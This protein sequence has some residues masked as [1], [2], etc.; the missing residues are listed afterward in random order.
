MCFQNRDV[1]RQVC[2][3]IGVLFQEGLGNA[4]SPGVHVNVCAV[5]VRGGDLQVGVCCACLHTSVCGTACV[6]VPVC[7]PRGN[8]AWLTWREWVACGRAERGKAGLHKSPRLL[9]RVRG[10]EAAA[11]RL[12]VK[13]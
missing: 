6:Y 3:E 8:R 2:K 12:G 5:C 7:A 9:C 10:Q 4:F 13:A 11:R 1:N